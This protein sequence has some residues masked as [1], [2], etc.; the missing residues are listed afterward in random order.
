MNLCNSE[1]RKDIQQED[2]SNP[3]RNFAVA[4]NDTDDIQYTIL[5]L[6]SYPYPRE[7]FL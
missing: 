1:N 2:Q 3:H 5:R 4:F 7:L 6:L